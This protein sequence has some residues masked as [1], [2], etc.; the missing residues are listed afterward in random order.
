MRKIGVVLVLA[1]V[2]LLSACSGGNPHEP[3]IPPLVIKDYEQLIEEFEQRLSEVELPEGT[4][5]TPPE[6]SGWYYTDEGELA[7]DHYV[8]GV[9]ISYIQVGYFCLWLGDLL[10]RDRADTEGINHALEKLDEHNSFHMNDLLYDQGVQASNKNIV[11]KA[12]LGDF[13][14]AQYDFEINC[15]SFH[16][17]FSQAAT[18]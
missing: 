11:D 18:P 8:E 5:I 17:Q 12:R 9:G 7:T 2:A 3:D 16:D 13:S 4:H 14:A 10:H 6:F 1:S 15:S